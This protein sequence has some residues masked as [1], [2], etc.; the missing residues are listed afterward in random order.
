MAVLV[1]QL[2]TCASFAMKILCH[3]PFFTLMFLIWDSTLLKEIATAT[4]VI[5]R[6]AHLYD[7]SLSWLPDLQSKDWELDTIV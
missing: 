7:Y 5:P 4:C 1:L 3:G 6:G 2:R